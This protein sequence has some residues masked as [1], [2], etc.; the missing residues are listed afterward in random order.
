[1]AA[2][3]APDPATVIGGFYATLLDCM[4]RGPELGFEGRYQLIEPSLNATFDVVTMCKIAIGPEWTKLSGGAK[5]ALIVTFNKYMVTT[6]ASRFKFFKNQEFRIGEASPA[7]DGRVLLK[8]QLIKSDG[9]AVEL[10]YLFR[11]NKNAWSAIDVYLAGAISQVAQLRAEFATTM[12]TGG[13]DALI[14]SLEQ[15]IADLRKES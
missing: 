12:Q 8:T 5:G 6:Y 10:N 4:K 11:L 13:A 3:S 2:Q 9:E 15:K 1:V 14:A 7:G